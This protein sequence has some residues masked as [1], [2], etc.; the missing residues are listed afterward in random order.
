MRGI[1]ASCSGTLLIASTRCGLLAE[2]ISEIDGF[3]WLS[4]RF[5]QMFKP[6]L[7]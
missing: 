3:G 2:W 1:G 6:L 4:E 5:L 7:R